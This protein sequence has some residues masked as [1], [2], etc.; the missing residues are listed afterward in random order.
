MPMGMPG[1]PDLA[2]STASIARARMALAISAWATPACGPAVAARFAMD[3]RRLLA[4]DRQSRPSISR[5]CPPR[6]PASARRI[7]AVNRRLGSRA[8]G[9]G[10]G[11][12]LLPWGAAGQ[13][14]GR[15]AGSAGRSFVIR[16]LV[17]FQMRHRV[18]RLGALAQLEM[19][20]RLIDGAGLAGLGDHLAPAN[21]LIALDQE[22]LVVGIGGNPA[23]VVADQNQI[24][25]AFELVAGVG[26]F[27]GLGRV[28]FRPLRQ[29]Q[30][31]AVV[32]GAVGAA[33]VT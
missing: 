32:V 8:V 24:A 29:G 3:P 15:A 27:A 22:L 2:C 26:D 13:F 16:A 1:W 21:D 19:Q 9:P 33:A 4:R 28:D 30:I 5:R 11:G 18:D 7:G 14:G 31:D 10:K 23:V 12:A 25:I 20:L 17:F 6:L